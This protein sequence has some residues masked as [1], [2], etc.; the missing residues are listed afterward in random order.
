[1]ELS[2]K[3]IEEMIDMSKKVFKHIVDSILSTDLIDSELVHSAAVL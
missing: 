2:L 3:S 1:M